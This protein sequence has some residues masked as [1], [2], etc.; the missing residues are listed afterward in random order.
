[1]SV[2]NKLIEAEL[3]SVKAELSG[4][5]SELSGLK[6]EISGLRAELQRTASEPSAKKVR[7]KKAKPEPSGEDSEPKEKRAPSAYIIF[8]SQTVGPLVR[9]A[10]EGTERKLP[11]GTI[12]QFAAHLWASMKEWYEVEIPPQWESH[13]PPN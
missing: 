4:M 6:A 12:T 5:K 2:N 1:M 3:S 11:V 9:R 10:I 7:A 8:S 13:T